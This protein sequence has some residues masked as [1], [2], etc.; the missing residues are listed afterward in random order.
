MIHVFHDHL[1]T[2][3]ETLQQSFKR[4][5]PPPAPIDPPTGAAFDPPSSPVFEE[6]FYLVAVERLPASGA[7]LLHMW[8]IAISSDGAL[9]L[10]VFRMLKPN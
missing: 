10:A 6:H 2:G 5:P 3:G 4:R 8:R 1:I 9:T 7:S